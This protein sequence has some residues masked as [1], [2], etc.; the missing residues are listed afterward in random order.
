MSG[1]SNDETSA[2]L[3]GV[4]VELRTRVDRHFDAAVARTP[5]AFACRAGCSDCCQQRLTV[6]SVEAEPIRAALVQLERDDPELRERIRAQAES[7]AESCPLLVE[8]RCS[9]YDARPLICRSH[10]L[11]L[12]VPCEE[13]ALRLDHCPLNFT[14]PGEPPPRASILVLEAVNRPLSALA[15]LWDG[16][17]SRISLVSLA[18]GDPG[19]DEPG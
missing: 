4:L 2:Q 12:G 18:Q 3:A 8:D 14:D 15:Q 17:G 11:P 5:R 19:S 10:G 1:A 9:V 13:D 7:D 16:H 6:F